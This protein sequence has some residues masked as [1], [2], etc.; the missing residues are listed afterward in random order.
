MSLL[1]LL[2][3]QKNPHFLVFVFLV[4]FVFAYTHKNRV[5]DTGS[6]SD[7]SVSRPPSPREDP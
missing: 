7:T 2:D 1:V 5:V 6:P 4:L 3:L